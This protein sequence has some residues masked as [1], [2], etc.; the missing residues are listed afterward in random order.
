M[1]LLDEIGME[2]VTYEVVKDVPSYIRLEANEQLVYFKHGKYHTAKGIAGILCS[3]KSLQFDTFSEKVQNQHQFELPQHRLA[4]L[5]HGHSSNKNY[6]YQPMMASR[7]TEMGFFVIRMD[8]R[9]LGDSEDN[10]DRDV[11][12]TISQ[13]VEDIDTIYEFVSSPRLCKELCGFTLTL[14]TIMA[15]SRGVVSMF[16]FARSNP[17]KYIPNLINL[18]GRFDG[19]GLLRKRLKD[20]ADWRQNGGYW[21]KFPRYGD[22]VKTWVPCSETL[23][24]V[25]VDAA[26]FKSID[27]R[28]WVLSCYGVNDEVIPMDAA[29]N[30]ANTFSGRHT[31]RLIHGANHNFLGLPND[32]NELNLPLR[33]GLVNYCCKLV[34]LV[35]EHLSRESQLERFYQM[36]S[37]V[38]GTSVNPS[39]VIARWPLPYEFSKVSNFRDLG[40]Y[41]T[42]FHG[43]RVKTG[44][45]YRCANP[46]DVTEDALRY[47]KSNLHL[48]RVFDLRATGEAADNGLFPDN[49][50]VQNIACN[51]NA[52]VSPEVMAEHYHGLLISSYSFP[53]AYMIVL[54][55]STNA[56]KTFF[57]YILDGNCHQQS[58]LLFHCTAGKDRTGVLG[59][60][61]LS[62]LGVDNDTIAKEYELTT[63]G[64]RTEIKLIKKLEA[65]G[66]LYYTMLGKESE[67]LTR[68]YQLTPEKMAK[69]LMSSV[70]EAMRFFIDDFCAEF[71]SVEQYFVDILEFTPH[72]IGRLRDILLE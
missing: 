5:L 1:V 65:R 40:G 13:D 62:I 34:D 45:V 16:E 52:S 4:L 35:A 14:D 25:E 37:I 42:S 9:G 23:S 12:R 66:D 27:K 56:I 22:H 68:I 17:D 71:Q 18:A 50:M 47:L 39:D 72:D 53:K 60:L 6:P 59:M 36:T 24:A 41:P 3:P 29:A 51:Q 44:C 49:D 63:I 57:Q 21:C 32:R 30:Y 11:G 10:R 43:R 33:K 38:R 26:A 15:H 58:S 54:K 2:K 70:Y 64:L 28:T 19:Q 20:C 8:F 61:L 46:C 7:L 67:K 55:N 48:K 69:T 31:L